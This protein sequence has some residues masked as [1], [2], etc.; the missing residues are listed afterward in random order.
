MTITLNEI[1]SIYCQHCGQY[2]D[3][4]ATKCEYCGE[5]LKLIEMSRHD[6][7]EVLSQNI[8]HNKYFFNNLII[9]EKF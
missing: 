3:K 6:V 5:K 8:E 2:S 1:V 7:R 4:N 9:E